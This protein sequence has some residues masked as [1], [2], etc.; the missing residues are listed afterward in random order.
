M[1]MIDFMIETAREAGRIVLSHFGH[2]RLVKTKDDRGDVVTQADL[3]SD[4]FI[5]SRI[6]E[7]F[8]QDGILT[9]ESGALSLDKR[10]DDPHPNPLPQRE[11]E[12]RT[13]SPPEGEGWG[14]GHSRAFGGART[15]IVDP[16]DGTRNFSRGVP[17][18]CVSIAVVQDGR[19][20]AGVV[21][22]PVHDELFHAVEGEGAFLDGERFQVSDEDDLELILIN[23]AWTKTTSDGRSFMPWAVKVVEKT[24]YTRRYGTA[25]LALAYTAA[26]RLHAVVLVDVKPWDVAAGMLMVQEAGGRVTDLSC[27]P[28]VLPKPS[29]DLVAANP[30]LHDR[31][32]REIFVP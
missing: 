25:E 19:P 1:T 28:I 11:R 15:W 22:D 18:F 8:P 5:I 21:Y 13:P 12:H 30:G 20:I 23:M 16:L 9:E 3:D 14:E 32:M 26:G 29:V 17:L 7:A 31:L 6:R 10:K 2:A 4:R 24:N 27:D